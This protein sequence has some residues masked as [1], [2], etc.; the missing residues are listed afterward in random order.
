MIAFYVNSSAKGYATLY[1]EFVAA[2]CCGSLSPSG[3]PIEGAVLLPSPAVAAA[4]AV[5]PLPP[6]RGSD[7]A[8]CRGTLA[9]GA[10]S[11][12]HYR[13]P[14]AC[15]VATG[16][17]HQRCLGWQPWVAD[18]TGALSGACYRRPVL[19]PAGS[20][21][22]G[23]P[24]RGG[25]RFRGTLRCLVGGNREGMRVSACSEEVGGNREGMRVSA[26]FE[27]VGCV[28]HTLEFGQSVE[29]GRAWG[30]GYGSTSGSLWW[31]LLQGR[32]WGLLQG[33][34]YPCCNRTQLFLSLSD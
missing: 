28:W 20:V 29:T 14:P 3:R 16:A 24:H 23:A 15:S 5:R 27:E 18:A 30:T 1:T 33:E 22:T 21:A 31:H 6:A 12:A 8:A 32:K 4:G 10:P 19:P 25:G 11:S 9:T 17:P 26:G 7:R 2:Q 13:L 34:P